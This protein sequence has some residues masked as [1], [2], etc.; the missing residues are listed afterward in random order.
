MYKKVDNLRMTDIEAAVKYPDNFII[1]RKDS[2]NSVMGTVLFIGNDYD[3]MSDM[4]MD[5]EDPT[6]CGVIEGMNH[7]RSLGGVV[8][9]A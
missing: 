2:R 7:R 6:N 9:G 5:M 3:E 8:R 4:L 1:F